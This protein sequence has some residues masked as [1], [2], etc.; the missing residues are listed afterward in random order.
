M[1]LEDVTPQYLTGVLDK[2]GIQSR[3]QAFRVFTAFFNWC[4]PRYLKYPPTTGLKVQHRPSSR[5]RVL[6]NDE[7]RA[8]WA[9]ADAME[10]HFPTILKLLLITGQRR[11]EIAVLKAE[12]VT[13]TSI[14]LPK[15]VTK[16]ARDHLFPIGSFAA[17]ILPSTKAG[18]LFPGRDHKDKPFNG[19][20]KAMDTLRKK[21]GS[22][23]PHFTLHDA[24][25]TLCTKWAEDLRIAPHLIERYVNHVSGQ[26]SG[27]AAIYNRATHLEELRECVDRWEALLKKIIGW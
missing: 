27:V 24:R 3:L 20:A 6:T 2:L 25:R 19:W 1:P 22:E 13:P 12:W 26:V 7:I 8:L 15:Q 23:F 11:G 5:T 18:L 21:L 17:S 14:C 4:V 16:N 10:G 9:A